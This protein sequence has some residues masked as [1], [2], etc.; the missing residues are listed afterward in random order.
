MSNGQGLSGPA[1]TGTSFTAKSTVV[2]GWAVAVSGKGA[3]TATTTTIIKKL[4]GTFISVSFNVSVWPS[5]GDFSNG[6]PAAI[7]PRPGIRRGTKPVREPALPLGLSAGPR[8][9]GVAA[10]SLEG[11]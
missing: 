11:V 2:G 3:A 7:D 1:N 9:R 4:C 6:Y 5:G 8:A 10:A